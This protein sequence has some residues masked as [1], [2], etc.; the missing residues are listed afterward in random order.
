MPLRS[1]RDYVRPAGS[2]GRTAI[3]LHLALLLI[4]YVY[5]AWCLVI[6]ATGGEVN[7]GL[8]MG[9]MA[10]CA[11]GAPWTLPVF[12]TDTLAVDSWFFITAAVGGSTLNVVLHA[13]PWAWSA[14]THPRQTVE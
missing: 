2:G 10:L 5:L 6:M 14:R 8:P 1:Q 12:S 4:V 13:L 7:I 11:L 3:G 9:L